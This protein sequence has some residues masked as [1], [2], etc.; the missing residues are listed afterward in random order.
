MKTR[1]QMNTCFT[2]IIASVA[3]ISLL[4]LTSAANSDRKLGSAISFV[5]SPQEMV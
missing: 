5:P 3:I 2:R 4:S 1:I